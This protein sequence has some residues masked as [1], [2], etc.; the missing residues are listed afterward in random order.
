MVITVLLWGAFAPAL[1][2]A[3]LHLATSR[4]WSAARAAATTPP[5]A[6]DDPPRDQAPKL[7]PTTGRW[8]AALALAGGYIAGHWGLAGG[9][10]SPNNDVSQLLMYLAAGG[11][12]IGAVEARW[13]PPVA[14]RWAIR[15]AACAASAGLLLRPLL[16]QGGSAPQLALAIGTVAAGMVAV[17][18]LIE[19]ATERE[20]GPALG[21]ALLFWI[22]AGAGVLVLSGTATVAQLAGA[23]AAA[24]GGLWVVTWRWS[25]RGRLASIAPVLGLVAV[26]QWGIGLLY[27][28]LPK[29]SF[30]LLV[31][32]PLGLVLVQLPALA[33]RGPF[34][35]LALR[36]VFVAMLVGPAVAIAAR[37][38]FAPASSAAPG[39]G[40]A[41]GSASEDPNYGY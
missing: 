27:A 5:A 20:P 36:L 1:L 30:V 2:A 24:L 33:R 40:A 3:A 39:S 9:P 26:G 16:A 37:H 17:W 23:L 10:L 21:L 32:A 7:D 28:E 31:L 41:T 25:A 18:S 14:L 13:R 12:L 8:G 19:G 15:L 11:G 38:Y 29:A 6:A 35:R 22:V 4:P 34:T